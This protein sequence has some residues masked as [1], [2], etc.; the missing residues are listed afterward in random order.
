MRI[1]IDLSN[2]PHP[3]L[4]APIAR[5]LEAAGAA[6][7]V[8]ARDNAQT[9]ELARQRWC[10]VEVIG[11]PSPAGRGAKGASLAAAGRATWPPGRGASAPT[12]PSPTTPTRRSSAARLVGMK[13]VTAMDYEHQPA[14][15]LAFRL[16]SSVLLPAAL[17][18]AE[19]R[20][21]GATPRKTRYYDGL[22]EETYMGDFAPD[23]GALRGGRCPTWAGGHRG[24]RAHAARGGALSPRREPALRRGAPRGRPRP[25]VRAAWCWRAGRSSGAPSPGSGSP[26]SCSRSAP[27][28]PAR[29]CMRPTWCSGRAAR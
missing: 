29:C 28:T 1:W 19:M 24:G 13:A 5:A 21:Y 12:S 2:S 18:S 7:R 22:K 23:P 10:D 25:A 8:T 17:A 11:G 3:L 9:V 14:N 16:A 27:W 4:F 6:V 15:H 20:R 26:T